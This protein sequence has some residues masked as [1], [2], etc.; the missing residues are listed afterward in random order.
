MHELLHACTGVTTGLTTGLTRVGVH[1]HAA[2]SGAS[3]TVCCMHLQVPCL[4][5]CMVQLPK[6]M[7]CLTAVTM[8]LQWLFNV[9]QHTG[10][11]V[12]VLC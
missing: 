12:Q 11:V 8:C 7:C 10:V 6:C 2:Y 5:M 9:Q 1:S 3:M 4:Q